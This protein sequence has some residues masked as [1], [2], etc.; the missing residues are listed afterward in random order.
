MP[1]G[2][3][4]SVGLAALLVWLFAPAVLVGLLVVLYPPYLRWRTG[5]RRDPGVVIRMPGS[6]APTAPL[7]TGVR[8]RTPHAP[9][10]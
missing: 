2:S 4:M 3:T 5:K 6:S 8:S 9:G 1:M 10:G 7:D